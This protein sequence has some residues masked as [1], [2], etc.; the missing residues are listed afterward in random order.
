MSAMES[1]SSE[2]ENT[3]LQATVTD[4]TPGLTPTRVVNHSVDYPISTEQSTVTEVTPVTPTVG[5]HPMSSVVRP[6]DSS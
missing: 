2:C 1:T 4:V 6:V 5:G 3:N